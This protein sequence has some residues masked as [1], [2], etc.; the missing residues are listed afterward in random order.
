[1]DKAYVDFAALYRYHL[2]SAF[3]ATRAK[4]NM[5]YEVVEQNFNIDQSIGLHTDKTVVLA[6]VKSKKL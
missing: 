5:R 3:F 6:G 2:A 4:D 1:M